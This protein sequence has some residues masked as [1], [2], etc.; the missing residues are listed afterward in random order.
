MRDQRGFA[1]AGGIDEFR[2][3]IA[4]LRRALFGGYFGEAKAGKFKGN[5]AKS[6]LGKR[7]E[8]AQKHVRRAAERR[9]VQKQQRWHCACF[10]ISKLQTIDVSELVFRFDSFHSM[11][12]I[13]S[14]K[15]RSRI[16][17]RQWV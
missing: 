17:I 12:Y 7:A 15:G 3:G 10:D 8:I 4:L 5:R 1:Q 11:H 14:Y 6:G 2:D 9:A 13:G 16:R